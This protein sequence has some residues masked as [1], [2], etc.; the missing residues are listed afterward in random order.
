MVI[1]IRIKLL[2][3]VGKNNMGQKKFNYEKIYNDVFVQF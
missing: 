1:E 3:T 2:K